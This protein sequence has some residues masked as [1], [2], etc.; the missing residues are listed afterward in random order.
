MLNKKM[1]TIGDYKIINTIGQGKFSKVYKVED[2]NGNI[3]ALKV[4]DLG[5]DDKNLRNT[6]VMDYNIIKQLSEG[7]FGDL[8]PK[9][10]DLFEYIYD[11]AEVYV[12]V[13]EYLEG[14]TLDDYYLDNVNKNIVDYNFLYSCIKTISLTL[15]YIHKYNI[16]HFL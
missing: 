7:Q 8:I 9:Y 15:Q 16:V 10:Y 4:I 12:I 13:M 1:D 6:V 3:F 11:G 14:I 2:A 5:N